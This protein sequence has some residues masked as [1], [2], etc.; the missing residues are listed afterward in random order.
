[1][2]LLSSVSDNSF[3]AGSVDVGDRFSLSMEVMPSPLNHNGILF[4]V[5]SRTTFDYYEWKTAAVHTQFIV[6]E[7]IFSAVS[8]INE[9]HL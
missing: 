6:V 1:M 4:S 8:S 7:F 9:L 3:L 5:G 2:L